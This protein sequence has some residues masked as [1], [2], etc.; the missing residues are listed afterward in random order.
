MVKDARE[1]GHLESPRKRWL[2]SD[3]RKDRGGKGRRVKLS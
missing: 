3:L 2:S 1:A